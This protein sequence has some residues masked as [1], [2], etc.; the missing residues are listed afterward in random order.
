LTSDPSLQKSAQKAINFIVAAQSD[1][2]GWRYEP[3]SGGDTSVVG[4]QVMA[5]K[6]GQMAGLEVP[7]R[8]LAG[9][10]KWLDSCASPD[11]GAYGYTGP[12]VGAADAGT[13]L[14][15]VGLL[16]REYLGWGPRNPGLQAGVKKLEKKKAR[17]ARSL[18]YTYYATQVMHHMGG[19]AWDLWNPET[20]D[21]LIASQDQGRTKPHQLGSWEPRGDAHGGPGGR[22]MTTSLA[23]LTLEVYYRHLPL[24]RRDQVAGGK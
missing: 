19:S 5:L 23:V 16:C 14:T 15:A 10:S 20:R 13:A 2:G 1:T 3:R 7:S 17:D 22:I 12:A 18:Y 11:Q 6:S 9:A 8:A 21:Y 4:W 24:Y